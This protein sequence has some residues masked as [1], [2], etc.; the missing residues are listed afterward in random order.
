VFP[1]F[2]RGGVWR[3]I[4]VTIDTGIGGAVTTFGEGEEK[5]I[6]G[7]A[8]SRIGGGVF[9]EGIRL[10]K[11]ST[12]PWLYADYTWSSSVRE[13]GVYLGWRTVVYTGP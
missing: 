2:W 1:L 4:G 10:W 3:E 7:G 12:G 6:D 9:Y 8:I 13:G 5:V 11:I